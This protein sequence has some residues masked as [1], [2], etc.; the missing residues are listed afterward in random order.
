MCSRLHLIN[1]ENAA[2]KI[3][4]Q[5]SSTVYI[6]KFWTFRGKAN[7]SP[8][9]LFK[10]VHMYLMAMRFSFLAL[11][12]CYNIVT[13]LKKKVYFFSLLHFFITFSIYLHS[14]KKS[15]IRILSFFSLKLLL[16][17][18]LE[19]WIILLNNNSSFRVFFSAK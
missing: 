10:T 15:K 6:R 14:P 13:T 1:L 5:W 3:R 18:D 2:Q 4:M 8:S 7:W 19:A 9:S 16:L 12:W 11:W 17:K